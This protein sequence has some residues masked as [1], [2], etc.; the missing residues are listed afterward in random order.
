MKKRRKREEKKRSNITGKGKGG[1]HNRMDKGLRANE[2]NE[3][4]KEGMRKREG[5]R[6]KWKKKGK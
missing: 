1:K 4:K 6:V 3:L 5:R 2:R